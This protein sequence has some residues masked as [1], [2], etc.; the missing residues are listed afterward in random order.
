MF[1]YMALVKVRARLPIGSLFKIGRSSSG[2]KFIFRIILL[3]LAPLVLFAC[4]SSKSNSI[5]KQG[6]A[7]P[8]KATKVIAKEMPVEISAIGSIQPVSS[9][10]VRSQV[11][12]RLLKVNF[13]EGALVKKGQPLFTIDS[14]PFVEA[15][16]EAQAN[17]AQS[18]AGYKVAQANLSNAMAQMSAARSNVLNQRAGVSSAVGNLNSLKAES[19]DALTFLNQQKIL[20]SEGVV[21]KRDLQ[22]AEAAYKSALAKYEQGQAQVNQAQVVAQTASGSGIEQAQAVIKQMQSQ[23]QA[24][25]AQIAQSQAAVDNAKVQL[26]YCQINSPVD[27]KAGNLIVTEGNLVTA[28]DQTPLVTVNSVSPIYANF[29]VPEKYLQQIQKYEAAGTIRVTAQVDAE[30]KRTG[31]LSSLDNQV[32]QATGTVELKATFVNDDQLLYAGRFVTIVLN[33][34]D[35]PD[36]VVVP[37]QAVQTSQQGQFVYVIKADQTAEMRKITLDRTV[38]DEAVISEGLQPGEMIIV[39]GQLRVSPGAKVQIAPDAPANAAGNQNTGPAT[40]GSK[41]GSKGG[42]P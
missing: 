10:A 33:L 17:L 22:V 4:S 34:T 27:G 25:Q 12:G 37:S 28:N 5:G 23:V 1:Q 41:N 39:D 32:D 19:D 14:R 2:S 8:V 35:Q 29:S 30:N 13:T 31:T 16:K 38:G 15:L 6:P 20:A 42:P 36:A 11:T 7:V 3:C 24:A 26:T 21:A 18:N 9:A 40:S